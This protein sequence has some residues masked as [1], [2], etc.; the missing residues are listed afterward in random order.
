MYDILIVGNGLAGLSAAITCAEAKARVLL[1]SS[2]QP[3]RSQSVMAEGGI[4]AALDQKGEDD[5]PAQHLADTLR[6]GCDLADAQAVAGLTTAAPEIIRWADRLGTVFSRDEEGR[7]DQRCFGGQKKK[8][9]A[10][11][12]AGIGRQLMAALSRQCRKLESEG[13]IEV[14]EDL[15]L[16]SAALGDRGCCG[17]VFRRVGGD[18][19]E[20]IAAEGL[21]L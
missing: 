21:I 15:R 13:R 11:A 16:V 19:P 14:R 20:G 6:A 5:S 1:V 18:E 9:T 2:N 8:R 4:N 12:N 7:V 3:E 17:G 10:Y